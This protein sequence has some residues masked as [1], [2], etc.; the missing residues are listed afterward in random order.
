[1]SDLID[2]QLGPYR[3]TGLIGRGGMSTVYKAHHATMN[4]DV[5]TQ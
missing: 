5:A 1:M 4:R 3:I 2:A